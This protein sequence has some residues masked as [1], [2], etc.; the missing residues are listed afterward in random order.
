[1]KHSPYSP[2]E[3]LPVG[4]NIN[5]IGPKMLARK[6][7]FC[8]SQEERLQLPK[9][10]FYWLLIKAGHIR[11]E[12]E[13]TM[14]V[15]QKE[16]ADKI[17]TQVLKDLYQLYFP[18]SF[19]YTLKKSELLRVKPNEEDEFWL[20]QLDHSRDRDRNVLLNPDFQDCKIEDEV[21]EEE[22]Y[23]FTKGKIDWS[24]E[25]FAEQ[26]NQLQ[27][28]KEEKADKLA[29]SLPVTELEE[30][31]ILRK[32]FLLSC[33]FLVEIQKKPALRKMSDI[34][35]AADT[36]SLDALKA[37]FTEEIMNVNQLYFG[38]DTLLHVAARAGRSEA[39]KYLLSFNT[40]DPNILNASHKKPLDY[41]ILYNHPTCAEILW[42]P[43]SLNLPELSS[44][45]KYSIKIDSLSLFKFIRAKQKK[46]DKL[47][48]FIS[49]AVQANSRNEIFRYLISRTKKKMITDCLNTVVNQDMNPLLMAIIYG[50]LV[51]FQALLVLMPNLNLQYHM[52][53]EDIIGGK[54]YFMYSPLLFAFFLQRKEMIDLLLRRGADINQNTI[55]RHYKDGKIAE[56]HHSRSALHEV[57]DNHFVDKKCL[58][59]ILEH[60]TFTQIHQEDSIEC[61]TPLH[62]AVINGSLE[63]VE[64]ILRYQ[65]TSLNKMTRVYS[66]LPDKKD[67]HLKIDSREILTPLGCAIKARNLRMILFLLQQ[68]G[69]IIHDVIDYSD[70]N[71][72]V[73]RESENT[74]TNITIVK[75]L[76]SN[77]Q[78]YRAKIG[79]DFLDIILDK[80]LLTADI[81]NI[82]LNQ[83]I[84]FKNNH[85]LA[86]TASGNKNFAEI[87][88]DIGFCFK[89]NYYQKIF[90]Y[91]V[92]EG[93]I[94]MVRA[95][96]EKHLCCTRAFN[97]SLSK[98]PDES[99]GSIEDLEGKEC[100]ASAIKHQ[101]LEILRLI[102]EHLQKIS[103]DEEVSDIAKKYGYELMA[104]QTDNESI[105]LLLVDYGAAV[106]SKMQSGVNSMFG[107]F[108][109]NIAASTLTNRLKRPA[110]SEEESNAKMARNH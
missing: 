106:P 50:N 27:R 77:A 33:A 35:L 79:G 45:L 55:E 2:D 58:E 95:L 108:N 25:E 85:F 13:E 24:E 9:K 75:L 31:E 63:L 51:A 97:H 52:E 73:S 14:S 70:L 92:R 47:I 82:F 37:F 48:T 49:R 21:K 90:D 6:I 12:S 60:P 36:G 98:K 80:K 28:L 15:K 109:A 22:V 1:M 103:P 78:L 66:S 34:Y 59:L 40:I 86:I 57:L 18:V 71:V 87:L 43:G 74:Q 53:V 68:E 93:S 44:Y 56:W 61:P 101:Q 96:L 3:L 32:G 54:A 100:I 94:E 102:L 105:I 29:Y 62:L 4:G 83:K 67:F 65:P 19:E 88:D 20:K 64:R 81:L 11:A 99:L 23:S 107:L 72:A 16:F 10:R 8:L 26:S 39:V 69:I 89:A 76:L 42:S 41:A 84:Q 104:Q 46:K 91:A 38:N 30:K 7:F 5:E 17:Y 110:D